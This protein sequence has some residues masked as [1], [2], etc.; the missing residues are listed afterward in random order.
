[1]TYVQ[2]RVILYRD[3]KKPIRC[4]DLEALSPIP[5]CPGELGNQQFQGSFTVPS[6]FKLPGIAS[7][8]GSVS[9][10]IIKRLDFTGNFDRKFS[11][12]CHNSHF[13]LSAFLAVQ[14]DTIMRN[15]SKNTHCM[16]TYM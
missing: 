10:A 16:S 12:F 4:S 14:S 2:V 13:L 8:F 3:I 1:M 11:H 5:L 15:T 7:T 6:S 9:K